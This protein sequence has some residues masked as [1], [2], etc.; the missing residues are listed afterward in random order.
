MSTVEHLFTM[1]GISMMID[2]NFM[3]SDVRPLQT[4]KSGRDMFVRGKA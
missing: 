4:L 2:V 3:T 1:H